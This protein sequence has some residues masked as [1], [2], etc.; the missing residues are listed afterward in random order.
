MLLMLR[1]FFF[2][3]FKAVKKKK[4]LSIRSPAQRRGTSVKLHAVLNTNRYLASL[5]FY[6]KK[7]KLPSI[8]QEKR[9]RS[10]VETKKTISGLPSTRSRKHNKNT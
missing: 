8:S 5:Q 6:L 7:K 2:V 4:V 10:N 3:K 1:T 9:N